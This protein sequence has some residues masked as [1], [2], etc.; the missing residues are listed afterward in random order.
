VE[1]QTTNEEGNV[2]PDVVTNVGRAQAAGYLSNTVA[3]VTTYHGNI[4]TGAGAAAVGDTSLFAETGTARIAITPTRVTRAFTN[5]TARYVF[6]Y[7]ATG[8]ITVT[9]AGYFTAST[10]GVLMQKSDFASIPLQATDSI[11]FTFE[12]QQT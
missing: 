3:Q 2:M 1:L 8:N 12:N 6:T 7:T 5:D 10:G 11:E 9:N 4:G